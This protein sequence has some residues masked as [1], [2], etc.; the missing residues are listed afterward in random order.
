[1]FGG[2]YEVGGDSPQFNWAVVDKRALE[3]EIHKLAIKN[4]PY[5]GDMVVD[6][7]E[8]SR[9]SGSLTEKI[10]KLKTDLIK[11]CMTSPDKPEIEKK[12]FFYP[13]EGRGLAESYGM[14]SYDQDTRDRMPMHDQAC[15]DQIDSDPLV[16]EL[17]KRLEK[18]S[19]V[20]KMW[21]QHDKRVKEVSRNYVQNLI[22][23]YAKQKYEVIIRKSE[24]NILFNAKGIEIDATQALISAIDESELVLPKN[25]RVSRGF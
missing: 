14:Y 2:C 1:M 12:P 23:R 21:Y 24:S 15:K 22:D 17:K 9:E 5:T 4:N 16:I 8:F 10:N 18:Y 13:Q 19:A 3:N 11:K 7:V 6:K 20:K 25:N